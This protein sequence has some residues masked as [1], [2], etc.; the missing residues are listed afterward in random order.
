MCACVRVCLYAC[1][2]IRVCAREC[3]VL[4]CW[5]SSTHTHTHTHTQTCTHTCCIHAHTHIS[6]HTYAHTHTYTQDCIYA[7][8]NT[9]TRLCAFV[10]ACVHLLACVCVCMRACVCA[11]ECRHRSIGL[12][13][14]EPCHTCKPLTMVLEHACTCPTQGT[15][16]YVYA[17]L[18]TWVR[19]LC[20]HTH[21]SVERACVRTASASA[22][23]CTCTHTPTHTR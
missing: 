6:T 8:D 19:G 3:V 20:T 22:G 23:C 14:D 10:C 21:K 7:C 4:Y 15:R 17:G 12:E 9:S 18:Y 5:A 1:A 13:M 2:C 16:D 11:R